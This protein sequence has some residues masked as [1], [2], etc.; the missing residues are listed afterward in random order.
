[1]IE[2]S[3]DKNVQAAAAVGAVVVVK[4][5]PTKEKR[6]LKDPF[7]YIFGFV[8]CVTR[9][10]YLLC[11]GRCALPVSCPSMDWLLLSFFSS[12]LL[13]LTVGRG[14]G[15]TFPAVVVL[16][17]SHLSLSLRRLV[18]SFPSIRFFISSHDF[19]ATSLGIICL[20]LVGSD[21]VVFWLV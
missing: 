18:S 14:G 9:P 20:S 6:S 17:P 11:C 19:T 13:L 16:F 21:R 7:F 2:E 1:M 3:V 15:Q 10:W 5:Q 12:L 8:F 4:G